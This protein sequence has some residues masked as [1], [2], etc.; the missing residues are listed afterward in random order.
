MYFVDLV[1][2]MYIDL[3]IMIIKNTVQVDMNA[4]MSMS[5]LSI[6]SRL[7]CKDESTIKPVNSS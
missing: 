5:I 6:Q 4:S 3:N 2:S 1:K 7:T